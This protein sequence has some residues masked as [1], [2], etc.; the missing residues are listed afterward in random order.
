[1]PLLKSKLTNSNI[2]DIQLSKID[3]DEL[4]IKTIAVDYK[5]Q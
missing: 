4:D 5:S 1:M 3:L 2:V